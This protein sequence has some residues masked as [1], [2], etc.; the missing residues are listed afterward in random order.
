MSATLAFAFVLGL[1]HA[2]DADH[3][4]AVTTIVSRTRRVRPALGIGLAWGVGHSMTLLAVG[5]LMVFGGVAIPDQ[6]SAAFELGVAAMLV[7]LGIWSLVRP[8]AQVS[9]STPTR[10]FLIGVIHGLAGSA[11][12]VLATLATIRDQ[13]GAIAYLGLFSIGTAAGMGTLTL[14]LALPVAFST[15]RVHWFIVRT[16]AVLAIL[17]GFLLALRVA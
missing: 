5:M 17:G 11:A 14:I 4:L 8:V 12:V 1:R 9:R 3:V 2:T 15:A 13:G 10:P 6:L 7:G 16:A